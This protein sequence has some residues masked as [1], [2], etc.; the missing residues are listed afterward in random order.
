VA[1]AL[2]QALPYTTPAD[3]RAAI[4]EMLKD[5]PAYASLGSISFA[6]PVTAKHW[7]QASNPSERWKWDFMFQEVNTQKWDGL[8]TAL[9][10]LNIIPLTPVQDGSKGDGR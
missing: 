8:T 2:G 3:V 4:A 9:P 10:Q 5:H 6:R 1:K 7:L